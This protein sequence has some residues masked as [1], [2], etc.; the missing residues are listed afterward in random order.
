VGTSTLSLSENELELVIH[1]IL[2]ECVNTTRLE[3][4][5]FQP[6]RKSKINIPFCRMVLVSYRVV[7]WTF[8]DGG[9]TDGRTDDRTMAAGAS[10]TWTHC[11]VL[12]EVTWGKTAP[13]ARTRPGV[14]ADGQRP[15]H[16]CQG[17]I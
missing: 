14:R 1:G 9:R 2:M 16:E 8:S 17:T 11:S 5:R 3:K 10:V 4:L 12:F 13:S 6:Y 7:T 15:G